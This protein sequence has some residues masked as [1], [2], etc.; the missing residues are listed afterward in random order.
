MSARQ[1]IVL[2]IAFI[3][4]IG[5]LLLIRNMNSNSAPAEPIENVAGEQVLVAAQDIPQGAA[6][7]SD[8]MVWRLFPQASINDNYIRESAQADA[9]ATLIGAVSRRP[10]VQGE[11]IILGSV[12]QPEDRGFMA[13]QLLPGYRAVAIEIEPMTA[14]G[15]FIQPNDRVDVIL[16]RTIEGANGA[17]DLKRAEIALHDVR[18]L[19]LG[20]AT[21]RVDAAE[22]PETV[23]GDVAVLELS[24]DDARALAQADAMGDISLALRGVEAEPAGLRAPSARRGAGLGEGTDTGVVRVHAYG[25]L[26]EGG[27]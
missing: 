27:R 12:V 8:D 19:A 4:A 10:F 13:A 26:T 6:L 2:G 1:L 14:A 20:D 25:S 18:V 22:G 11:P 23:E 17:S 15:G 9:N 16:T 5:A 21:Q 24:A 7:D 3:A